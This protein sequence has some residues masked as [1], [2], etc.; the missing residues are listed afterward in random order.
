MKQTILKSGCLVI[1]IEDEHTAAE[2]GDTGEIAGSND[3]RQW[4][5][6]DN[7]NE[8]DGHG[9]IKTP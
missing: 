1:P 8:F 6:A 4:Q 9:Y 7:R 3:G 2:R 5:H